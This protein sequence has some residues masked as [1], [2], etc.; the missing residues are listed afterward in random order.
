MRPMI[1]PSKM[2]GVSMTQSIDLTIRFLITCDLLL[3]FLNAHLRNKNISYR[4][5]L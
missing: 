5:I 4:I 1:S 3:V 2:S